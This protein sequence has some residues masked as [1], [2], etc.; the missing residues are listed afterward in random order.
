MVNLSEYNKKR[1]LGGSQALV[2]PP[3]GEGAAGGDVKREF[4]RHAEDVG[5]GSGEGR[6]TE[7]DQDE[8]AADPA[9]EA[10][11]PQPFMGF[12]ARRRKLDI[13]TAGSAS[14]TG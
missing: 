12:N 5:A 4:D 1:K 9:Q 3:Q 11:N 2:A 8:A 7:R 6:R 13:G 10:D 14:S